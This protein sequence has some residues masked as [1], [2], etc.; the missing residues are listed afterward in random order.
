MNYLDITTA[1]NFTLPQSLKDVVDYLKATY[2]CDVVIAGGYLR[3]FVAKNYFNREVTEPKDVDFYVARGVLSAEEFKTVK[4]HLRT[5][6]PRVDISALMYNDPMKGVYYSNM[7]HNQFFVPFLNDPQ[8]AGVEN[9]RLYTIDQSNLEALENKKIVLTDS[10]KQYIAVNGTGPD[11]IDFMLYFPRFFRY[12]CK[13]E[14]KGFA[15]PEDLM[16]LIKPKVESI[17]ASKYGDSDRHLKEMMALHYFIFLGVDPNPY[18]ESDIYLLREMA[19]HY[20]KYKDEYRT[21]G[22]GPLYREAGFGVP[23]T[24]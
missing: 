21:K 6:D 22:F 3:D 9:G 18:L 15:R 20:I 13:Q 7:K 11:D 12:I 10:I 23:P 2:S 8:S 4:A 19:K 24:E 17:A 1:T 14:A 5:I 16:D